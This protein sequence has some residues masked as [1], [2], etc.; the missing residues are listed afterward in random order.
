ML[1]TNLYKLYSLVKKGDD[2]TAKEYL[3][4]L[5]KNDKLNLRI[6]S[7][8]FFDAVCT[9]ASFKTNKMYDETSIGPDLGFKRYSKEEAEVFFEHAKK[10]ILD[11]NENWNAAKIIDN[12]DDIF[13]LTLDKDH[14]GDLHGLE[15]SLQWTTYF[16]K[17]LY[18][19]R[20]KF[21]SEVEDIIDDLIYRSLKGV[22]EC[23]Y[24]DNGKDCI[25]R[26][27]IKSVHYDLEP[28]SV[29]MI[30][31]IIPLLEMDS[32]SLPAKPMSMLINVL[33]IFYYTLHDNDF[34]IPGATSDIDSHDLM[35]N[36]LWNHSKMLSYI[37]TKSIVESVDEDDLTYMKA[38]LKIKPFSGDEPQDRGGLWGTITSMNIA[39]TLINRV[40]PV[41]IEL[42]EFMDQNYSIYGYSGN[43]EFASL[44]CEGYQSIAYKTK[45]EEFANRTLNELEPFLDMEFP[46]D[47]SNATS[48]NVPRAGSSFPYVVSNRPRTDYMWQRSGYRKFYPT[49]NPNDRN[50]WKHPSLDF[51]VPFSR[52]A[53][54]MYYPK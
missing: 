18:N 3:K 28:I 12:R 6:G 37:G 43:A 40:N 21:D 8:F 29:D 32:T 19:L 36:I 14:N 13:W 34:I 5:P 7:P 27:P 53:D 39:N 22:R 48:K 44:L 1:I 46:I 2:E 51:L 45:M 54:V 41:K 52:I 42:I 26:H 20:D 38:L 49:N 50:S 35:P 23:M 15:D 16:I 47:G 4:I 17:A 25:K 31:G 33:H 30:S 24:V 10:I 9:L 11:I